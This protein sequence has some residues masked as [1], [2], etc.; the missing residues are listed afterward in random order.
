M[1]DPRPTFPN[2]F[3]PLEMSRSRD[4]RS[5]AK[6]YTR[7]SKPT[8]YLYIDFGISAKFEPGEER[9]VFPHI[10]GDKSVPEFQGDGLR[11]PHDPFPTDIYYLGNLIRENFLKAST[12]YPL[13]LSFPR[14]PR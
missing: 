8:R 3:H 13:H 5:S 14:Y 2:G 11:R 4:F 7:T 1:M 9:T 6:S 10:G 12:F